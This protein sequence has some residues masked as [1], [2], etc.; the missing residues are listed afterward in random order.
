MHWPRAAVPGIMAIMANGS[1]TD[2]Q[3]VHETVTPVP[4]PA[5]AQRAQAKIR[6]PRLDATSIVL[7][8]L[9]A[10][11][12]LVALAVP[13]LIVG[14]GEEGAPTGR[15]LAAFACTAVGGLIMIVSSWII[16]RRTKEIGVFVLGGVP[17]F[18][19]IAGGVIFMATKLTETG[20]GVGGGG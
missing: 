4:R 1:P 6:W 20:T 17:A 12:V 2:E 18:S 19:C 13:G 16:Y 11:G 15:V 10:A 7:I 5:Q 9:W 14:P 8:A 3:V